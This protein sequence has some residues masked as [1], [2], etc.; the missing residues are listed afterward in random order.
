MT[1]SVWD[2]W[3]STHRKHDW[4]QGQV[5]GE[6]LR[7]THSRR[8]QEL[9]PSHSSEKRVVKQGR[10][11]VKTLSMFE[12]GRVV[13]VLRGSAHQPSANEYTELGSFGWVG[14]QSS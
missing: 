9:D 7:T 8:V 11:A 12:T 5:E 6:P 10:S 1:R 3:P 14:R 4:Q 13:M 2:H